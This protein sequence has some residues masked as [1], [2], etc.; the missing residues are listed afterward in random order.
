MLRD[1]VSIH[2]LYE[3]SDGGRN[4]GASHAAVSI[5]ALYEESDVTVDYIIN[6]SN[7]FQSTLSMKRA[8]G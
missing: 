3:E 6:A 4:A 7:K 5:H 1:S 2:A 8:T